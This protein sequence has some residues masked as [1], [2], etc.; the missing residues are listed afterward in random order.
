M[1]R[2][3]T[4]DRRADPVRCAA[5]EGAVDHDQPLVAAMRGGDESALESLYTR[6]GGLAFTLALRIVGDRDLA[7]E[8]VQDSFFRLWQQANGYDPARGS[9]T[10]WLMTVTR[11]RA[12]D[13]LRGRQ[14]QARL[15]ESVLLTDTE[16]D[17]SAHGDLAETVAL[18]QTLGRAVQ[19]LP[20]EQRHILELAYYEG[21]TRTEIADRLGHPVGTVKTRLRAALDRLRG[22]LRPGLEQ[23]ELERRG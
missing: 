10:A 23:E 15:R 4:P 11:N 3:R 12:I 2:F 17:Q 20:P 5:Y 16:A 22:T 19:S 18:R 1:P 7:V 6:Y 9:V 21:L 13:T 14:H 8:V